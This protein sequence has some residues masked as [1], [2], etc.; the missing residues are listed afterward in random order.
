MNS[1]TRDEWLSV[2]ALGYLYAVFTEDFDYQEQLWQKAAKEADL[3]NVLHQ[4]HEQL[5]P[6]LG[7][8]QE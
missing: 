1:L 6:Y 2:K 4:V 8:Q 3:E 7:G 5:A